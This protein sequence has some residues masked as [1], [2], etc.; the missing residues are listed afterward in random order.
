[1]YMSKTEIMVKK[2][3]SQFKDKGLDILYGKCEGYPEPPEIQDVKPDVIGWDAK[4]ELYHIGM[5]ADSD[6]VS[7]SDAEKKMEVLAGQ[8]MGVGNSEGER[9]PFYLG[10]PKETEN[11]VNDKL[12]QIDPA[13]KENVAKVTV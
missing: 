11:T 13:T 2:M 1:M 3:I 6:T 4:K 7:S 5:V 9:L 8:M 10:Y 12:Q